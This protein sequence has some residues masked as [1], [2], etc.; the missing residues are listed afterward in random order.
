MNQKT[1]TYLL[2]AAIII[3][4]PLVIWTNI[5]YYGWIGN[6]DEVEALEKRVTKLEQQMQA[7]EKNEAVQIGR[8]VG[9]FLEDITK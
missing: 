5:W 9:K 6:T 8:S 4:I 2:Y 7:L 1:E 3:I